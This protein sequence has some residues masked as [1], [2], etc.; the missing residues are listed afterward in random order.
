MLRQLEYKLGGQ[1]CLTRVF[2]FIVRK[3]KK[4]MDTK[5]KLHEKQMDAAKIQYIENTIKSNKYKTPETLLSTLM[6]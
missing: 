4:Q 5:I 1:N 3:K 6:Y 2:T